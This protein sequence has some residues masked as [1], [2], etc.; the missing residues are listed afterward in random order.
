M[1]ALLHPYII[2]SIQFIG[3][4]ATLGTISWTALCLFFNLNPFEV[5]P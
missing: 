3:G 2:A 1:N 5:L 4:I